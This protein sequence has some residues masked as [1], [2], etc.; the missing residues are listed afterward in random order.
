MS[1]PNYRTATFMLVADDA[2]RDYADL[3]EAARREARW[4]QN[5]YTVISMKNDFKTIYGEGVK[6][7]KFHFK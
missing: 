5:G 2:V 1:N 4:R 6:K 7:T 3:A